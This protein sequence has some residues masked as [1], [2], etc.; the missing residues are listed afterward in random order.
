MERRLQLPAKRRASDRNQTGNNTDTDT[1][2]AEGAGNSNANDTTTED[3]GGHDDGIEEAD[4]DDEADRYVYED[5]AG[6]GYL[7]ETLQATALLLSRLQVVMTRVW[8][9][10]EA[11][12]VT[13]TSAGS[14][15]AITSATAAAPTG[16]S[17]S[18]WLLAKQG[19]GLSAVA[20]TYASVC[21][22][23]NVTSSG[24]SAPVQGEDDPLADT[25]MGSTRRAR[26]W[27]W[28]RCCHFPVNPA[29]AMG[30]AAGGGKEGG[31]S[32]PAMAPV[33]ID[34]AFCH[35]TLRPGKP[36][37]EGC[38]LEQVQMKME[39]DEGKGGYNV[40]ELRLISHGT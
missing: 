7:P 40:V 27:D 24:I 34:P 14:N 17:N 36:G 31:S 22:G 20:T 35:Q 6:S 9:P 29:L 1:D 39:M 23:G 3:G 19:G 13:G 8:D 33:A 30:V 25:F 10:S 16:S 32:Q 12:P 11:S 2:D 21:G 26:K 28:S 18:P 4:G 5:T 15:S 38:T 37:P